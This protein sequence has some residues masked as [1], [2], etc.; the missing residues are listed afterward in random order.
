MTSA[1]NHLL[2]KELELFN[3]IATN[4]VENTASAFT[5]DLIPFLFIFGIGS[6]LRPRVGDPTS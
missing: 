4:I 2:K 3:R 1:T 5:L 6:P